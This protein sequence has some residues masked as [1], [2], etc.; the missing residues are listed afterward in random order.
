MSG[1][2]G[3]RDKALPSAEQKI[4]ELI[5][6]GQTIGSA[7]IQLKVFGGARQFLG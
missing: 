5:H 6:E 3:V 1:L 4:D 7:G 2:R